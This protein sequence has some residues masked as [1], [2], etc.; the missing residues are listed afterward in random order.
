M[1]PTGTIWGFCVSPK[2]TSTSWLQGSG[3]EPL[4]VLSLSNSEWSI[5]STSWHRQMLAWLYTLF[6][7]KHLSQFLW[8]NQVANFWSISVECVYFKIPLNM[9]I[10]WAWLSV[11]CSIFYQGTCKSTVMVLWITLYEMSENSHHQKCFKWF[12]FRNALKTAENLHH[13]HKHPDFQ[14]SSA[15]IRCCH[16][17]NLILSMWYEVFLI[18]LLLSVRLV[19]V[20]LFISGI[21]RIA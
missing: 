17:R 18:L 2:E 16:L 12:H 1:V 5:C 15:K 4:I 14:L 20:G 19:W 21:L 6:P 7:P 10:I 8:E 9:E 11:I 13:L 3:I